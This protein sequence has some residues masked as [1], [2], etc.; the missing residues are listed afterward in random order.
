[1]NNQLITELYFTNENHQ[2][3]NFIV[4]KYE[5]FLALGIR[6][7]RVI[8]ELRKFKANYKRKNGYYPD[9][10]PYKY[11]IRNDLGLQSI[12]YGA[13]RDVFEVDNETVLKLRSSYRG[14]PNK[15][16][17]DSRI[18]SILGDLV[19]KIYE[20]DQGRDW[21]LMERVKPHARVDEWL[22]D[23]GVPS[24]IDLSVFD[25]ICHFA[26]TNGGSS[27]SDVVNFISGKMK[28]MRFDDETIKS[29]ISSKIVRTMLRLYDVFGVKSYDIISDIKPSNIGYA[30]DGRPV[31]VD[32]GG[33]YGMFD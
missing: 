20:S 9:F 16:E 2:N 19:P 25:M 29:F 10:G 15:V 6:A 13:F 33:S 21:V 22:R 4:E 24:E 27:S 11:F 12:G 18:Y 14:F 8:L 26:F 30:F 17:A 32:W 5:K 1:M 23:L 31:F 28:R 7:S 3:F